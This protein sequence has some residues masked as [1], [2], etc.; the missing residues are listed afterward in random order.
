MFCHRAKSNSAAGIG[1]RSKLLQ[2]SKKK[3]IE[4]LAIGIAA[5]LA[6]SAKDRGVRCI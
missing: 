3:V 1:H 6:A 2:L 5:K 4:K